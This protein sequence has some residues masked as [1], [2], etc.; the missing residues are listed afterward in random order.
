MPNRREFAAIL[1]TKYRDCQLDQR[2]PMVVKFTG[3]PPHERRRFHHQS[4]RTGNFDPESIRFAPGRLLQ[5]QQ[6]NIE[7]R[8]GLGNFI[9]KF[10][11][12]LQAFIHLRH[13]YPVRQ[14]TQ[15]LL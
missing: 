1:L 13:Q 7:A 4:L 12:E 15:T 5:Q 11:T 3:E 8:Q 9:P 10:M 14:L 2:R 6:P